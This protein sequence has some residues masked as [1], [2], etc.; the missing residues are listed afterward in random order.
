MSEKRKALAAG[1]R[2]GPITRRQFIAGAGTAALSFT[3]V[4]SRLVHGYAANSKLDLGII[5]CGGRGT[6]IAELFKPGV[7]PVCQVT[8]GFWRRSTRWP[9]R[10]RHIS[11]PSRL[12]RP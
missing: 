2:R 5:G 8:A 7:T 11:T 10:V 3:V 6:G 4:K 9:S 1:K 12:L